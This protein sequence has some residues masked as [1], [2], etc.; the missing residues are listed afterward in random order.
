MEQGH[1]AFRILA[2]SD[3]FST[4]KNLDQPCGCAFGS[5]ELARVSWEAAFFGLKALAL[6]IDYFLNG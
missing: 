5:P 3:Q 1:W 6:T 4:S 2:F